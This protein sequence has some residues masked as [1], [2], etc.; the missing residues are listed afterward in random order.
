MTPTSPVLKEQVA[1]KRAEKPQ[2]HFD[3]E[4]VVGKDILEL[5]SSSMYINPLTI[6]REYIQNSVD[7]IDAAVN[8]GLL[9]RDEGR[10]DFK[11]DPSERRVVIRDN[12]IGLAS[13]NFTKWMTAFGASQKRG[14]DARGFRGVGRLAGL[15]Y[16]QELIFRSQAPGESVINEI[17]WDC[18]RVKMLLYDADFKG[19][20]NDIVHEV[21]S[22]QNYKTSSSSDH[23][24]EVEIRKPLRLPR[25]VLLNEVAIDT[26]LSQ[27]APIP[28]NPDYRFATET[29]DA[30][31]EHLQLGEFEIFLGDSKKPIYRPYKNFVPYSDDRKG[32]IESPQYFQIESIDGSVAAAGWILHHDYQ[33]AIPESAGVKG[34]RARIGNIQVGGHDLFAAIFPETRFNSWTIGEVHIIDRRIVPNGRRDNF[35]QN[36]H[37]SNLINRLLPFTHDIARRCRSNSAIRNRIKNFRIGETKILERL[38]IL[39]QGIIPKTTTAI[40]KKEIGSYL[41]EIGKDA[42]FDLI[43]EGTRA[44]LLS[45]FEALEKRISGISGNQD[46]TN[47]LSTLSKRERQTFEKVFGLI[48]E[49]SVNRVAAKSLIDR[50]LARISH[51]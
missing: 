24:F 21:V 3:G 43:N 12:G 25:D 36:S 35:E 51:A 29:H 45:R 20:L 38:E 34:L 28:F 17:S 4:I 46:S 11:I 27:V 26:Y 9:Q 23:F 37:L 39:E 44:E 47:P 10:V 50:I 8:A 16:C 32:S 13:K 5:L 1:P 30:L 14:T 18:R 40:L 49:C 7:A 31:S 15:G 19:D 41:S 48:Y 42:D 2:S 6:Y 33:G 22:I